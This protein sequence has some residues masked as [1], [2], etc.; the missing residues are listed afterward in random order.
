MIKC[1]SELV[2]FFSIGYEMWGKKTMLF[3]RKFIDLPRPLKKTN[4]QMIDLD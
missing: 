1:I 4:K 3:F 2:F